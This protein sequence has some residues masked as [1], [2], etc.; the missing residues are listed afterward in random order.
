MNGLYKLYKAA[1]FPFAKAMGLAAR[2]RFFILFPNAGKGSRAPLSVDVKYPEN[3]R[4]GENVAIGPLTTLGGYASIE[5]EDLVRI[6]KGVT[7]ESAGLDLSSPLP[8]SH[9]GKPIVI[10]RGAWLGARCVILAGVTIG[11]N[12]VIGA[13]A[14]IAKDVGPG[15]VVVAQPFRELNIAKD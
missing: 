14:I 7:I 11:E 12:A 6:S 3:I 8:Y 4:I 5:L 9:I 1:V 13:G 15:K 10:K 2:I